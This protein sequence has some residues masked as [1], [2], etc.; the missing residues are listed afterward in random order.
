M[1][2]LFC[3]FS[4][5]SI[6]SNASTL[7]G[8]SIVKI[9]YLVSHQ[10]D[11][12]DKNSVVSFPMILYIAKNSSRFVSPNKLYNDSVAKEGKGISIIKDGT[13]MTVKR[14][15]NTKKTLVAEEYY[16]YIKNYS[17]NKNIILGSIAMQQYQ[18]VDILPTIQWELEGQ[19]KIIAGV[20]C[21]KAKANYKGRKWLVW[22]APSSFYS[23]GP[24]KLGGLPGLILYAADEKE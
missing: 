4:F 17:S 24:W 23:N 6:N 11:S 3:I 14:V 18:I 8:D 10:L 15:G 5:L 20:K 2:T 16:E 13:T 1:K 19:T 22:Y 12:T 9:S 21:Q 7:Y